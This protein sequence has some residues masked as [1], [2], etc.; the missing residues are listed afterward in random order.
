MT[1]E[2]ID[3][4]PDSATCSFSCGS[5]GIWPAPVY[6][7]LFTHKRHKNVNER[8]KQLPH[9]QTFTHTRTPAACTGCEFASATHVD[10]DQ[11]HSPPL[12]WRSSQ[13]RAANPKGL[14]LRSWD[15]NGA[16]GRATGKANTLSLCRHNADA[17]EIGQISLWSNLCDLTY[18]LTYK[19][20]FEA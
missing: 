20:W 6:E 18:D 5:S 17:F 15:L 13:L 4:A 16:T 11:A 2:H 9:R 19:A 14:S 12:K 7:H 3:P 8:G 10:L 1:L